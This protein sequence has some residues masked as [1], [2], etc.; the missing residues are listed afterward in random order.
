[1][2]ATG[3]RRLA[4]VV[5]PH[6]GLVVPDRF[7]GPEDDTVLIP[8]PAETQSL[9]VDILVEPGQVPKDAWPGQTSDQRTRLVGRFSLYNDSPDQASLH[10][11]VVSTVRPESEAVRM[12]STMSIQAPEGS[13]PPVS[14]RVV[15]FQQVEVDGQQLPVLTEMPVGHMPPGT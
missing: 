10:F 1:M 13:N 6:R 7:R 3:M 14:P 5:I 2:E 15:M 12:L 4:T 11:T 9:E 8:P